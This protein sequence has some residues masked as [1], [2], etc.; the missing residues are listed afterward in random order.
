VH[1]LKRDIGVVLNNNFPGMDTLRSAF[2]SFGGGS[3]SSSSSSTSAVSGELHPLLSYPTLR[4]KTHS[5][6]PYY[7]MV[8]VLLVDYSIDKFVDFAPSW[9]EL[10]AMLRQ[11]ETEDERTDY[12]LQKVTART[13]NINET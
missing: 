6:T 5:Q 7:T 11:K 4:L 1:V 13:V 3:S 9:A 12:D 2:G 8:D 10:D